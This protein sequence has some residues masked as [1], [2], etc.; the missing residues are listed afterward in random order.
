MKTHILAIAG[1]CLIAPAALAQNATQISSVQSGHDCSG[2][3]LFQADLSYRNLEGLDLSGSRLR[4]ADLSL[5]TMN[6]TDFS[7]TD[8][9]VTNLFAGRFTSASFRNANLRQ[10]VMVGGYFGSADFTGADLEG[11][12]L[13]G[14]EL[15]TAKGL[16]QAQLDKTCG[17]EA[18][19]LPGALRIPSCEKLR[20]LGLKR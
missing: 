2:C 17:D 1:L 5:S 19:L 3:N 7:G 14:A 10:S 8:L 11:A 6:G 4:Q 9:S 20:A 12:N 18:T 13:S 16:T 15:D